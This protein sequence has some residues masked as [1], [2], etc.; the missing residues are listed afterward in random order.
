MTKW[1]EI[2][3]S[4]VD[5]PFLAFLVQVRFLFNRGKAEVVGFAREALVPKCFVF[6]LSFVVNDSGSQCQNFSVPLGKM[7]FRAGFV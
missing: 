2:L 4:N 7:V 5:I 3:D 1:G 6:Q